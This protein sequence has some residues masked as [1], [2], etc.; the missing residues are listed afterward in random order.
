MKK[1]VVLM[2]GGI[3]STVSA[4]VAKKEGYLLYALT[5]KYGQRHSIELEFA[6]KQGK[7]LG[8]ENHL[9]FP[10]DLSVIGGSALTDKNIKVPKR[11]IEDIESSGIPITYVPSRNIIFLSI[12]ASYAEVV[13]ADAIFIGVNAIDYSGYPDCRP[14]FIE[15]FERAINIGTKKGVEGKGFKI[16]TPVIN[17]KKSEIIKLGL[18][19]GVDFSLTWSCYDPIQGKPC[20]RCDSCLLR[21]KGFEEAGIEDPLIKA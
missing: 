4:F 16:I 11:S 8:V 21:R 13:G 19:L 18:D 3:D 9:F 10:L 2:S 6:R 20:G 12:A 5:F 7:I 14:E 1:A 17:L 15:A